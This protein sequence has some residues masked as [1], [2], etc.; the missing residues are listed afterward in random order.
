[1]RF[2]FWFRFGARA[3]V[4][5]ARA[6]VRTVL[7]NPEHRWFQVQAEPRTLIVPPELRRFK[8]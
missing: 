3:V 1:M 7:L 4:L 5:G 6:L 2:L 8:P